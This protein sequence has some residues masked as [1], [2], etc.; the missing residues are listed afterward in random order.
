VSATTGTVV[1]ADEAERF[2]G[3]DGSA[4]WLLADPAVTGCDLSVH[5]TRLRDGADG[6]GPHH[7]ETSAEIFYVIA[8][9]VELL[10]GDDVVVAGPGDLVAVPPRTTHAFGAVAGHDADLLVLTPTVE[11]FDLFR[12][13]FGHA[14]PDGDP[15]RFDTHPDHSPTWAHARRTTP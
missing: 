2:V 5:H 14:V 10:V 9:Q 1:R 7:H 6:A 8:G 4:L 3:P 11:R 12:Q 13:A 15:D